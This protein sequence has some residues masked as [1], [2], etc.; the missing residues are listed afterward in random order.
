MS[1][2]QRHLVRAAK[3]HSLGRLPQFLGYGSG[4]TCW[5]RLHDWNAA[6]VWEQLH[7]A[8]LTRLRGH[9]QI[10]WSRASIDGSSVPSPR[11][12]RKRAPTPRIEAN[13]AP[14]DTSL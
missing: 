8:M 1:R 10:D 7:Q 9:D 6:G 13:A 12:A 11:G 3:R 4:M 2:L 14:S 5:W